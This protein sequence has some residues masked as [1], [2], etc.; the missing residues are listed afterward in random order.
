MDQELLEA[1]EDHTGPGQ[2]IYTLVLSNLILVAGVMEEVGQ[3]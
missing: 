1:G 2:V 3:A